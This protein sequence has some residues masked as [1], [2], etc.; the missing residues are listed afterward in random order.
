MKK[1]DLGIE[2][3][4]LYQLKPTITTNYV[5]SKLPKNKLQYRDGVYS[6]GYHDITSISYYTWLNPTTLEYSNPEKRIVI[7]KEIIWLKFSSSKIKSVDDALWHPLIEVYS[8]KDNF[9]FYTKPIYLEKLKKGNDLNEDFK[10]EID[11]L[12]QRLLNKLKT[13]NI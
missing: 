6:Y 9:K 3:G 12:K 2:I 13:R 8:V 1:K 5:F 10:I 4:E 11:N 7:P